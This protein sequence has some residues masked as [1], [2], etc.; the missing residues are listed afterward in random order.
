MNTPTRQTSPSQSTGRNE[1]IFV[2]PRVDDYQT[3]LNGVADDTEVILLDPSANGVEQIAQALAERGEFD[4]IH[5]VSHGSEGRL[6]LGSSTLD[7]ETLPSYASFLEQWGEA[8]GPDGD[9]LIYGCDVGAGE[10][11]LRFVEELSRVTGADVAASDDL[12][13]ASSLG[14][15]WVL[16]QQYG[17]VETNSLM[18][19]E[20]QDTWQGLLAA[21]SVFDWDSG[22]KEIGTGYDQAVQETVDGVTLTISASGTAYMELEQVNGYKLGGNA[23]HSAQNVVDGIEYTFEFDQA[24]NMGEIELVMVGAVSRPST[25]V[26]FTA[27]GQEKNAVIP[28]AVAGPNDAIKVGL[29]SFTNITSF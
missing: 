19:I 18:S 27:G 5:L 16:E 24:V 17:Q 2:D 7:S 12:T 20:Q 10:Q 1:V 29:E 8:L 25:N 14:G 11:G 6:A 26:T 22:A 15:D 21:E 23:A 13:G 3:L 9:I 28:S 4:A